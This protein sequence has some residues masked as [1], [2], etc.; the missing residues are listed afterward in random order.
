LHGSHAGT[1][2]PLGLRRLQNRALAGT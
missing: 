1:S 2:R